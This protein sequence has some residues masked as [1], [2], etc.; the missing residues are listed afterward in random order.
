VDPARLAPIDVRIIRALHANARSSMSKIASRLGMPESTVRHRLNRLVRL[1]VIEFAAIVNPLQLGYQIWAQ[2]HVEVELARMRSVAQRL[3]R[4]R[5]VYFVGIA[6]GGYD[7]LVGAVFRTNK[8]LLDFI[9]GPMAKVPGIVGIST[10][11]ILEVVKRSMTFDLPEEAAMGDGPPGKRD[12]GER[13]PRKRV[14]A[15]ADPRD[16]TRPT[17]LPERLERADRQ[18][19]VRARSGP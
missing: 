9:T 4:A 16:P 5:Q 2:F 8:E 14:A 11:S 17:P 1:G 13:R 6:T 3:A 15:R 10:S 7:V 18:R 19:L 12:P